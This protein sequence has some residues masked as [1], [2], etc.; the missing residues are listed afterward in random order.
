MRWIDKE[1]EKWLMTDVPGILVVGWCLYYGGLAGILAAV[2]GWIKYLLG[3]SPF[4]LG[5]NA[6]WVA[7][8]LGFVLV[9]RVLINRAIKKM[10][11]T[12]I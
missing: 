5:R 9:G 1:R 12:S 8:C 3:K 11:N 10:D 6:F 7:L 4:L 2:L